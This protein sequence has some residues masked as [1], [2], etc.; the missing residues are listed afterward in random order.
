M[1]MLL[2]AGPCPNNLIMKTSRLKPFSEGIT[3]NRAQLLTSI[4][5]NSGFSSGEE[6]SN[7]IADAFLLV[8]GNWKYD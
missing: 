2:T 7:N 3:M 4:Y 6:L 1:L 5:K 8:A